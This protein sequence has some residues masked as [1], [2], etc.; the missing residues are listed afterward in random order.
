[1]IDRTTNPGH[2]AWPRYG[3]RGIGVCDRWRDFGAFLDDMGLQPQGLTLER[4]K[5]HLGYSPG[6][7]C[8]AR[9]TSR[10]TLTPTAIRQIRQM[11]PGG[12]TVAAIARATGADPALWAPP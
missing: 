11:Q 1:M 8:W 9:N 3:G 2:P 10:T 5:N 7:C 12:H 4:K 6:N